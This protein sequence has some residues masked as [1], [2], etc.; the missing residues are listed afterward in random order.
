M[1]LALVIFVCFRLR[2]HLVT[3]AACLYLIIVVL[4]SL[5]GSFRI[6]AVLSLIGVGELAYYL[7]PPIFSFRVS[8]PPNAPAIIVFLTTSAII[9]RLVSRVSKSAEELRRREAYLVDAQKL[10]HT[11]S[12]VNERVV[13]IACEDIPERKN[14]DR[15]SFFHPD[16]HDRLMIEYEAKSLHRH[17][18]QAD[19]IFKAFSITKFDGTGMELSIRRAIVESHGGRFWA[20]GNSPRGSSFYLTLPA[21][22][23]A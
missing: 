15:L 13:L 23:E 9:T 12:L 14:A 21:R 8:D 19:Q 6:S 20:A 18:F 17:P 7:A 22:I 2:L 4:L 3:A 1:A 10:N 11:A 5:R 16:D